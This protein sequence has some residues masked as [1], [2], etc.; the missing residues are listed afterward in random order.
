MKQLQLAFYEL[1]QQAVLYNLIQKAKTFFMGNN[2]VENML[3]WKGKLGGI[4]FLN[5]CKQ[6]FP[7]YYGT[8]KRSF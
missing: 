2:P 5:V 3:H 6:Q 4:P 7:F 1:Y 8:K